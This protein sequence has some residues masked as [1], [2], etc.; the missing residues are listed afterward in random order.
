MKLSNS[1]A[2]SRLAR[3]ALT[4]ALLSLAACAAAPVFQ[5]DFQGA[6]ATPWTQKEFRN[7]PQNFQFLV[8]GDRTGGERQ[9]IFDTAMEQIDLLQP[10]FVMSI[11]DLI[12]GYTRDLQLLDEQ[13]DELDAKVATLDMP[14]FR[15]VGN[16]DLGNDTMETVWLERYGATYYYFTY[17]NV[18]F[19]AL[20]SED[21]P[22]EVDPQFEKDLAWYNMT[23]NTDPEAAE[24]FLKE[25]MQSDR[26]ASYRKPANFSDKQVEFVRHA[27]A[28]NKDVR[29]TFVFFHQPAWEN[30]SANWTKIENLLQENDRDYTVFAGHMHYYSHTKRFGRDYIRMGTTGGSFHKEGPGNLDHVSWV[31]MTDDGPVIGNLAMQGIFAKDAISEDQG[32]H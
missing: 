3:T 29:W 24:A 4:C 18:L 30:P 8:I 14:F 32:A 6:P 28:E 25:F 11:G 23:K 19:I 7:D 12:E 10:E 9:G 1:R 22:N 21:P 13:W 16:H 27:L 2:T 5:S 20:N 17:R 26:L 31:T 15:V